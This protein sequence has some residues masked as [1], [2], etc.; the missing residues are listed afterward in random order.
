MR[1]V[2]DVKFEALYEAVLK[3]RY[4]LEAIFIAA[5][6]CSLMLLMVVVLLAT[7]CATATRWVPCP[8][9]LSIDVHHTSGTLKG[10]DS[11]KALQAGERDAIDSNFD[12]IEVGGS[13]HFALGDEPA[14]CRTWGGDDAD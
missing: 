6:C 5:A 2:N 11:L 12:G 14:R 1:D 8:T 4:Y 10:D 9:G 13:M 7:G 3:A